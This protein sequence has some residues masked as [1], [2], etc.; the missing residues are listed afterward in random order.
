M[1]IHRSVY[2]SRRWIDMARIRV[3]VLAFAAIFALWGTHTFALI[4]RL[5]TLKEVLDTAKVIIE[6]EI[7]SVDFDE[8]RIIVKIESTIKG[9]C[10]F[11]RIKVNGAAGQAWHP[12]AFLKHIKE[13]NPVILFYDVDQNKLP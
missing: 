3:A 11:K 1:R 12:K 8:G 2:S 13:G 7:E 9:K 4:E 6:G 5:Y 10:I